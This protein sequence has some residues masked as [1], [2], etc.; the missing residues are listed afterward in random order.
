VTYKQV[1]NEW[2]IVSK[3][4]KI[5]SVA[6]SC[7]FVYEQVPML[8]LPPDKVAIF[9]DNSNCPGSHVSTERRSLYVYAEK[10]WQDLGGDFITSE[11]G[12]YNQCWGYEGNI[13]VIPSKKKFPDLL[14]T[15]TGTE[16]ELNGNIFPAKNAI[17]VFNGKQYVEKP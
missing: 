17:Y 15:K 10:N 1:D 13:S 16:A 4:P 12:C 7:G 14:I 5:S 3:Q 8:E 6:S 9:I 2:R 11:S